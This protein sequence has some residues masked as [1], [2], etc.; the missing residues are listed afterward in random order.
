MDELERLVTLLASGKGG[1]RERNML[2]EVAARMEAL[3]TDGLGIKS[4]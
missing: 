1:K 4:I 3:K 2:F